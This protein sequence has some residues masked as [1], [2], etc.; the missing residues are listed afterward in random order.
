[1]K[2]PSLTY[3][4]FSTELTHVSKEVD[5]EEI[6]G[7]FASMHGFQKRM[8]FS[9][10]HVFY[11]VDYKTR[12]YSLMTGSI[13]NTFEHE[14]NNFLEGGLDYT[15]SV[16]QKESLYV[17]SNKIFPDI[18]NVFNQHQHSEHSSY[19][20]ETNII[21][22]G[23]DKQPINILQRG[24]YLTDPITNLPTVSFGICQNITPF[25]KDTCMTQVI[26]KFNRVEGGSNYE[27][28]STNHYFA[29]L[30]E[31]AFTKKERE[32]LLYLAE[33]LSSK[34]IAD[35]MGISINTI[36]NHRHNMLRKTN[37][38]NTTELIVF[39]ARNRII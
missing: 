37:T 12:K 6:E 4:N 17:L 20:F 18:A 38:K 27:H 9:R 32:T 34:Q 39:A 21:L 19:V 5:V 11:I 15:A 3:L 22:L 26:T 23:K 14:P 36:S 31:S 7:F 8:F 1:M 29:N 25:M 10:Q 2:N 30:E 13:L 24:S 28:Y 35:K 33:G 16:F